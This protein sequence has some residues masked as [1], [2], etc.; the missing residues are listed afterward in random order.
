MICKHN[1]TLSN[2]TLLY[3]AHCGKIIQVKED[4]ICTKQTLDKQTV[5]TTMVADA[6]IE[7]QMEEYTP[8]VCRKYVSDSSQEGEKYMANPKCK[9]SIYKHSDLQVCALATLVK[10]EGLR[11]DS[12]NCPY[13]RGAGE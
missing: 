13:W 9:M 5:K 8:H 1:K 11:E 2:G 4:K 10:C 12:R 3:C 7:N 6:H